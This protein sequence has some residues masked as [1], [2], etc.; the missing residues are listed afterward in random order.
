MAAAPKSNGVIIFALLLLVSTL[1]HIHKLVFDVKDYVFFYSYLPPW[2]TATR[3]AF[4][5]CQRAVGLLVAVGLLAQKDI[6]RKAG[7]GV[8]LFTIATIYWKHP[9]EG[10]RL[11]A[12]LLDERF[13][14]LTARMGFP[15]IT[16]SSLAVPSAIVH[17]AGDILFWCIF[18]YFF[19]R[20]SVKAQFQPNKY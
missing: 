6:A 12:Q 17:C 13:G 8:G 7:I 5:W 4:S 10:F 2:L 15:E 18:I 19:T 11:H 1:I 16:F 9:A 3:Y 20:P 14:Q